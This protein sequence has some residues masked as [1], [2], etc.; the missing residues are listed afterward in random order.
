[1]ATKVI[2]LR[3]EYEGLEDKI[4][5]ELE[6]SE[7]ATIAKL[8]YTILATFDTMA[9]HLFEFEVNG[10]QIYFPEEDECVELDILNDKLLS[11]RLSLNQ[12]FTMTYDYGTMQVFKCKVLAIEDM[13]R[14]TGMSYPKIID[15]KG[16][17]IVDDVPVDELQ[18]WIKEIDAFDKMKEP[19]YYKD[20]Q[21][22]WDYRIYDIKIDNALLKGEVLRIAEG[23]QEEEE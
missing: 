10:K 8:G 12:E 19:F 21:Y 16:S 5:R 18:E 13:K 22:K 17:G 15:G 1:M 4:W 20:R 11:L 23:Y 7:N 3:V 9:Y 14:G 2:K 6:I